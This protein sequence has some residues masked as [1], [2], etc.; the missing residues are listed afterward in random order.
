MYEVK[1]RSIWEHEQFSLTVERR[2][3][4]WLG[5]ASRDYINEIARVNQLDQMADTG[6]LKGK[7][8]KRKALDE[9]K[10]R[11]LGYLGLSA[12]GYLKLTSLSLMFGSAVLPSVAIA[13]ATMAGLKSFGEQQT[14][15]S[16][17]PKDEGVFEIV[18]NVSPLRS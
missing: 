15:Q 7:I 16:I 1:H 8:F 4:K 5:D 11:G 17:T 18:Y 10:V 12:F 9:K 3:L 2:N 6:A 13:G 14:I